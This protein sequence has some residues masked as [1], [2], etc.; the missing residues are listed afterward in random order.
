MAI[1]VEVS[2]VAMHPLT[3]P[4]GQ[5]PHGQDVA[6][7]IKHKR[8]ALVQAFPREDFILDRDEARIVGLE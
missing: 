1:N 5:P 2:F 4:V 6:R 7:P 3:N 8:I